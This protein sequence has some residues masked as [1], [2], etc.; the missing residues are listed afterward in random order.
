[1]RGVLAPAVVALAMVPLLACSGDPADP[2][3]PGAAPATESPRVA[4][5]ADEMA[6]AGWEPPAP[7]RPTTSRVV[8]RMGRDASGNVRPLLDPR[9]AAAP[10]IDITAVRDAQDFNGG[11]SWAFRLAARAP[12]DPAGRVIAYGVVVDR[13]G[14]GDADCQIGIDN[15]S[16]TRGDFHVW[17]T[18]LR[19]RE[20]T[21]RDGP[22]YGMPVEFAHP[23][24]AD[25]RD[26]P[27]E[28][29]FGFLV[30]LDRPAP[31]DGLRRSSTFY[32]WSSVTQGGQVVARDFA[33][34]TAW[35]PITRAGEEL[36]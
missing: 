29:R 27:P 32:V 30:G 17:V 10:D 15:D 20:T 14:D 25:S 3:D 35:M 24:E 34:D 23:A 26:H 7:L 16:P 2:V 8:V 36:P 5:G 9:D 31:C 6:P 19:T 12:R 13:D 22:P 28:M 21:V 11:S 1:M 18:N 33:P 4:D